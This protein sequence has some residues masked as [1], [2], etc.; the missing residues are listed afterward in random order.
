MINDAQFF[1]QPFLTRGWG[2]FHIKGYSGLKFGSEMGQGWFTL[3]SFLGP[4]EIFNVFCFALKK[5]QTNWKTF[6]L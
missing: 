2:E 6:P 4:R 3:G 5:I 1:L